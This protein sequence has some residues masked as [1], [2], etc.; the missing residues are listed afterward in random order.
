MIFLAIFTSYL[1][2]SLPFAYIV[3]KWRKGV[4]IREVGSRN[5]GAMNVLYTAGLVSGLLVLSLDF[6]KGIAAVFIARWL[7]DSQMVEMLAGTAAIAGHIF[8]VY[9]KFRGGKGGA[10][11][12]GVFFALMPWGIPVFFGIFGLIIVLTRFLTLAYSAALFCYPLVAWLAYN[13]AELVIFSSI[14]LAVLS[15][16]Y[17]PR[18]M[19]IRDAGGSWNRVLFRRNLRDRL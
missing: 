12:I 9:L 2:G 10:T 16:R 5:M 19:Q 17:V 4:D 15:L 13:S 7:C 1:I 18:V 6:A 8:P 11:C 14:I 3:S